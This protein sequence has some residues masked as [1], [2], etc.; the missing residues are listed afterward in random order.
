MGKKRSLYADSSRSKGCRTVIKEMKLFAA[1]LRYA[2]DLNVKM[3]L[4]KCLETR[5]HIGCQVAIQISVKDFAPRW[6]HHPL[7]MPDIINPSEQ[8]KC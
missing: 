7:K 3:D 1:L 8:T 5:D 4:S 6:A 2:E